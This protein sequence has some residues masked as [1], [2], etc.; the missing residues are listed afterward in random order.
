MSCEQKTETAKNSVFHYTSS[1]TV[2]DMS[3][4]FDS[5]VIGQE[6]KRNTVEKILQ[7]EKNLMPDSERVETTAR[8]SHDALMDSLRKQQKRIK[9][10][11]YNPR[12]T[13]GFILDG[14][15][16]SGDTYRAREYIKKYWN[17]RWDN[18]RKVWIVD[19]D[20]VIATLNSKYNLGLFIDVSNK[21]DGHDDFPH[22]NRKHTEICP[23]C[24]TYCYGDCIR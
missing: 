7:N 17:G 21:D 5:G 11:S 6:E 1:V 13:K 19:P 3:G 22:Q 18:Q 23:R 24:G 16:L 20:K 9:I 15:T 10:G 2:S 4:V 8:G 12:F 14:N